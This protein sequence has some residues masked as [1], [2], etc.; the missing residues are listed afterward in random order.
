VPEKLLFTGDEEVGFLYQLGD[1]SASTGIWTH[2]ALEPKYL[3][4]LLFSLHFYHFL[5]LVCRV[6]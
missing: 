2:C 1:N 5:Q 6:I 4:V 3:M